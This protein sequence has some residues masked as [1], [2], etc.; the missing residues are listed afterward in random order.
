MRLDLR[1]RNRSMMRAT[2]NM[3]QIIRGQMGHPAA[4]I[5]ESKELS[6]EDEMPSDYGAAK[7]LR[8]VGIVEKRIE[9]L[10]HEREDD[11]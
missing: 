8:R 9:L 10:Q 5:I 6:G 7:W 3:E 1:L 11:S 4:C 2:A